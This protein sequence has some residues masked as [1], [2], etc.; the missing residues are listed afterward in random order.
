MMIKNMIK[1]MEFLRSIIIKE[2]GIINIKPSFTIRDFEHV[3]ELVA[4]IER[5]VLFFPQIAENK[6]YINDPHV[7]IP[8]VE[9]VIQEIMMYKDKNKFKD[10][11]YYINKK[12]NG[13]SRI[14]YS[15]LL[16]KIVY[17]MLMVFMLMLVY[18]IED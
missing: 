3:L 15:I 18:K 14:I 4:S 2:H 16:N 8:L 5:V 10:D 13:E 1:N 9:F 17:Y 6:G 11:D 12:V 7:N